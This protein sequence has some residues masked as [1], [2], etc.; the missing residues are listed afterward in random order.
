MPTKVNISGLGIVSALG[1]GLEENFTALKRKMSGI[2]PSSILST[3]QKFLVGES[4]LTNQALADRFAL[5]SEWSRT[6][7]LGAIALEEAIQ[8]AELTDFDKV[9]LINGTTVAGMDITEMAVK[10]AG[11]STNVDYK[12][13]S[14]HDCGHCTQS[15]ARKHQIQDILTISTACSSS[16]NAIM[17]GARMIRHKKAHCVIVG[18]TDA[19]SIFTV[20]GFN[21]LKIL[22][23]D[24]CKP[25][26]ANREGL[27]L[28]EGAAY[29]VLESE[30]HLELR[31]GKALATVE[32]YGNAND[33]F[34]QTAS[35]PN[36]IGATLAIQRAIQMAEIHPNEIGYIN[37]H[38]TGTN[39]NDASELTAFN[40][41]FD[42]QRIPYSSTKAYTGHTLG[43]AGA[44][45]A[46]ASILTLT[47]ELAFPSLNI[48]EHMST[49]PP[50]VEVDGLQTDYVMSNSFGFG[51]NCTT[52]IFGRA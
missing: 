48:S 27:N 11:G 35:S 34:H 28:G 51:G 42:D 21:A 17:L 25:F 7:I 6:T 29:L 23:P 12:K 8:H 4:P 14:Q 50:L 19:L 5:N 36:A 39:N 43:A 46:V 30:E 33:A 44:V 52:L 2:K 26:D 37:A 45:E 31:N 22:D 9:K 10:N 18:G 32:G 20:N 41:V 24:W 1:I 38:G 3:Q 15:L 47:R 40:N 16:A 13:L 49:H